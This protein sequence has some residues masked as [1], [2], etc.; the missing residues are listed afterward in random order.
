M[1]YLNQFH[2]EATKRKRRKIEESLK[3]PM[4]SVDAANYM[5]NREMAIEPYVKAAEAAV[6]CGLGLNAGHDLN[7]N[8]LKYFN[9]NIPGLL[10]VSIGHALISDALY[11]G[12][13]NTIQAYRRQLL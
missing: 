11:M 12:L 1:T 7:L 13:E 9:G 3:S 6:K 4:N 5:K 8:N 2:K 10:E